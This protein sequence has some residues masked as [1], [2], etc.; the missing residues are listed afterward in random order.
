[1][2]IC[3]VSLNH[4]TDVKMKTKIEDFVTRLLIILL[5]IMLLYCLYEYDLK[6]KEKSL[7]FEKEYKIA[8]QKALDI[9]IPLNQ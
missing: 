8:V 5:P 6:S 4:Q 9:Y 7:K 2:L 1:M 3:F